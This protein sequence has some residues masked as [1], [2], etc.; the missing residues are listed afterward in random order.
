[1]K[2]RQMFMKYKPVFVRLAIAWLGVT[3]HAAT[4]DYHLLKRVE[5]GGTGGWDYLTYDAG[6]H[7][8]CVSRGTHVMLLDGESGVTLGDIPGTLGV[9]GIA[10]APE[11][12]RGFTSNGQ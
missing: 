9:H 6:E 7:V 5:V 10:L 3:L 2:G 4:P 1:M 12:G 8:V 11:L